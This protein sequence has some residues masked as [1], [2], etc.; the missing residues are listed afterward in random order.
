[1]KRLNLANL[2][3]RRVL[4]GMLGGG[5]VAVSLPLLDCFLNENAT[6]LA[7]G[8]P[9]PVRF[10][11]Y[12]WA[13]GMQHKVFV[14]KTIGANYELTPELENIAPV[15]DHVNVFTGFNTFPDSHPNI[16][17]YTGWVIQQCG[18]AP[19]H[20]GDLPG[21]S[22]DVTVA[23]QIGQTT[24]FESLTA[25]ATGDVRNSYSYVN[26]TSRNAAEWSP[27]GFY[28]RLFGASW[29]SPNSP[30]WKPDPRI[31][32]RKSVLS[33][34][35]E[36]TRALQKTVG[37]ADRARLEQYFTDLR[38]LEHQLDVMLTKPQPIASCVRPEPPKEDPPQGSDVGLVALREK[39]MTALMVMAVECDQARVFNMSY[40]PAQADTMRPGYPKS[41]HTNTHEEPI[42]PK[43]GIQNEVSWFTRNAMLSWA[44][45]VQAFT[46]IKE[47][48]GTLLDNC[49]IY[50]HT[51]VAY[52]RIHSLTDF[53][54]FTAGRA[55]GRATTG[56]HIA[57]KGTQ[58]T[59]VGLTAMRLVGLDISSWGTE[60]NTADK[61]IGEMVR[62]G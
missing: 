21:E 19:A 36:Q 42:D 25:T 51:D 57:G 43:T 56:L 55:G 5:A 54:L 28:K 15:R 33:G 26:Q 2:S 6:A 18:S 16:V 27:V 30:H 46:K 61:G 17:H 4:R 31:M 52:A 23:N 37:Y 62:S 9:M 10:G 7:T 8:E 32:V 40:A 35:L 20:G 3:R 60:S 38:A 11:T 12:F 49:L 22:I 1:M 59:R 41:H 48:D 34:V 44:N 45:F 14:P 29:Q 24:R 50:A 53:P 39:M 58:A 13:L 47:G